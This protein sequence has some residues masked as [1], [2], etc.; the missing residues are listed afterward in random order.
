MSSTDIMTYSF[1]FQKAYVELD[2]VPQFHS[3][4]TGDSD[5]RR[6]TE[7]RAFKSYVA[8]RFGSQEELFGSTP[9][10]E[11]LQS[12]LVYLERHIAP[13][14]AFISRNYAPE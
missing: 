1:V 8:E 4:R 7:D 5:Y 3:L 12:T 10:Y 14:R 6:T 9:S 11:A 13:R 2:Y